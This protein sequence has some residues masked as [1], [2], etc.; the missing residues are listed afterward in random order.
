MTDPREACDLEDVA[1]ALAD[2]RPIDW[3]EVRARL[4]RHRDR[5]LS[6]ELLDDVSRAFRRAGDA[7]GFRDG[8]VS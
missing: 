6:L 2:G 5:L 4:A 8:Y 7:C 3:V 1:E